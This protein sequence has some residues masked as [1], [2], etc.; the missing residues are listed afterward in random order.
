MFEAASCGMFEQKN[1]FD[2]KIG[3]KEGATVMVATEE[4]KLWS[5][6][7]CNPN[8]SAFVYFAPAYDQNNVIL[9]MERPGCKCDGCCD[10]MCCVNSPKPCTATT[11]PVTAPGGTTTA[12]GAT[13]IW[14]TMTGV[15]AVGSTRSTISCSFGALMVPAW[16]CLFS[17]GQHC[18][19]KKGCPCS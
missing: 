16:R 5:R 6:I 11:V 17:S 18:W 7:C 8:H 15:T 19:S 12:T 4:S 14:S 10:V 3:D 2:I 9:T 1:K 13:G